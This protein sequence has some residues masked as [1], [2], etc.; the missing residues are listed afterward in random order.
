MSDVK[1][2]IETLLNENKVVLFMK[3]NRQS[4]ELYLPLSGISSSFF[5]HY[6]S[7]YLFSSQFK[8]QIRI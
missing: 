3:G 2:K 4:N 5:F 8:S 7:L 1:N 6:R